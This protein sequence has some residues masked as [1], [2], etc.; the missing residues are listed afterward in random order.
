MR[1]AT[2]RLGSDPSKI[3][4]HVPVDL[5]I[6]HSVQVRVDTTFKS[7]FVMIKGV[8]HLSTLSD[9]IFCPN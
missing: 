7:F 3:N 8:K 6:D 2:M 1:D 9:R 5:V 4:P